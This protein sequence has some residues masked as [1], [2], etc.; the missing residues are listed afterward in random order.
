[1]LLKNENVLIFNFTFFCSVV[2]SAP[3]VARPLYY[4]TSP[5]SVDPSSCGSISPARKT[6]SVLEPNPGITVKP[7]ITLPLLT[8]DIKQ[9]EHGWSGLCVSHFSHANEWLNTDFKAVRKQKWNTTKN[10]YL[11]TESMF[12]H[13]AEMT[14]E[15]NPSPVLTVNAW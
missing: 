6:A 15:T 3:P 12:C 10:Y 13:H 7:V 5:V 9:W 1:M 8:S 11:H 4:S 2:I 14:I